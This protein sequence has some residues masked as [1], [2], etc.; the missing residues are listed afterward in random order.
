MHQIVVGS[1]FLRSN[2]LSGYGCR[3]VL[4]FISKNSFQIIQGSMLWSQFSAIFDNFRRGKMAL[5]SKY[6]IMV[7]ILQK[8]AVDWAK[9]D[10][11]LGENT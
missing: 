11:V 4:L 9:N 3:L 1:F 6:N 2:H 10:K 5:F 7:K 8:L